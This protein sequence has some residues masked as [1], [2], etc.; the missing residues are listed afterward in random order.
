MRCVHCVA[1]AFNWE[2]ME[3]KMFPEVFHFCSI[4]KH[5]QF[6]CILLVLSSKTFLCLSLYRFSSFFYL[7]PCPSTSL[8]VCRCAMDVC[9]LFYAVILSN[10]GLQTSTT[11]RVQLVSCKSKLLSCKA[12]KSKSLSCE[13]SKSKLLSRDDNKSI[14]K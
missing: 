6:E 11:N 4:S 14:L 3:I 2:F 10:T 1:N 13:V 9:P 8:S 7:S 12:S 5:I